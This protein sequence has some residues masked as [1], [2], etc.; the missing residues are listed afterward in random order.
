MH[1]GLGWRK[2]RPGLDPVGE[3]ERERVRIALCRNEMV[4]HTIVQK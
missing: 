3:R 2:E 1:S 4:V